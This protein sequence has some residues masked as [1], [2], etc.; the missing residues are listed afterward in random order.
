L[1]QAKESDGK[2]DEAAQIYSDVAKL[3][4]LTVTP[5]TANLRLASVYEKQ[6]KKKEAADL[7]FKHC[8][9]L[10]KKP[11]VRTTNLCRLLPRHVKRQL[12]CKSLI[13]I[14]T[15]NYLQSLR[16]LVSLSAD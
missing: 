2:F 1:G 16:S 10:T 3:N 5:E 12:S 13:Q 14:V 4:S 15:L 11:R 7:L 6:G 8:R 9:C